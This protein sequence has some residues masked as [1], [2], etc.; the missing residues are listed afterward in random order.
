LDLV[1]LSS[2]SFNGMLYGLLSINNMER[3]FKKRISKYRINILT[4][5]ALFLCGYGIYLG[6]YLRW[7]SWDIIISPSSLFND[8]IQHITHPLHHISV[9]SLTTVFSIWI[10]IFYKTVFR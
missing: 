8:I 7:N 10:Y 9:W 4:F 5:L 2:A 6:R 1:I 3:K